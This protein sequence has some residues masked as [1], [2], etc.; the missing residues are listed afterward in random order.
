M[1][2]PKCQ[3]ENVNIQI[4]EE[5]QQTNKKGIGFGGKLNNTARGTFFHQLFFNKL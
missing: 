1:K 3:S 4:V 2:C 5:G